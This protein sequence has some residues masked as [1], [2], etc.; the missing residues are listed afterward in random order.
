M[1]TPFSEVYEVFLQKIRDYDYLNMT[2]VEAEDIFE[3][4]LKSA[5]VKFRRCKKDLTDLDLGLKQF[6]ETLEFDDVEILASLLVV[7]YLQPKIVT[8]ETIK[9]AMGDRDFRFSSQA[10]HLQ[11]LLALRKVMQSDVNRLIGDYTYYHGDL[12]DLK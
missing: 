9:L 11:Q 2:D 6:N 10:N 3:G 5:I 7:E 8:Q 4:Y 1:A 12:G